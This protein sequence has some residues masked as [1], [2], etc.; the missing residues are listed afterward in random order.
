MGFAPPPL[1]R[2]A[3]ISRRT[4]LSLTTPPTPYETPCW[5]EG[6]QRWV[7]GYL[8]LRGSRDLRDLV[9]FDAMSGGS[10]QWLGSEGN[11]V[12]NGNLPYLGQLIVVCV[13]RGA[14]FSMTLSDQPNPRSAP[15]AWPTWSPRSSVVMPPPRERHPRFSG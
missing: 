5:N 3:S 4:S 12:V 15:A 7:S 11:I 2:H 9:C 14:V 8:S 13:P 1:V 10:Y 6:T